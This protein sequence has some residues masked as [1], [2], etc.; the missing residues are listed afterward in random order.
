MGKNSTGKTSLISVL[1]SQTLSLLKGDMKQ[2]KN[3][4]VPTQFRMSVYLHET[5]KLIGLNINYLVFI[6]LELNKREVF[7]CNLKIQ[8]LYG[9]TDGWLKG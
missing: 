4:P 9:C 8:M 3:D 6:R 2:L 5:I 1:S 7:K